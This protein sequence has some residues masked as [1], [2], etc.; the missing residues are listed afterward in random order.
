MKK[1]HVIP[2]I[3]LLVVIAGV[4]AVYQVYVKEQIQEFQENE[5]RI[6]ALKNRIDR[7]EETFKGQDGLPVKPEVAV[8]QW[9]SQVQPFLEAVRRQSR[10]FHFGQA[11]SGVPLVPEN[12]EPKFHYTTEIPKQTY[13]L[14]QYAATNNTILA[15][16]FM[17]GAPTVEDMMGQNPTEE[18]VNDWLT[19]F[20]FGFSI[21][22][23]LV[24]GGAA[25]INE[26]VIWPEREE[27]QLLEMRTV[28][29]RFQ[30]TVDNLA[31]FLEQFY[32]ED[33]YF[34]VNG[35]RIQNSNLLSP[36][37][38]LLDI[39][40]VLT[41]AGFLEENASQGMGAVASVA[42][43]GASNPRVSAAAAL[44]A[45]RKQGGILGRGN[46]EDDDLPAE[47]WWKK[48]WPF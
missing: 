14:Q 26:I 23:M 48:L 8:S 28:G 18:E 6:E 29:L 17:F 22:K 40:L 24:D 33:R 35:I 32:G 7:F 21:V 3:I 36:Q 39:E 15:R 19:E 5:K 13:E 25:R 42:G 9:R 4:A 11:M 43:A 46:D 41:Q 1:H 2:I 16:N 27:M 44:S 38:P 10:Y 30:M 34:N 37:K 31:D 20:R 45:L 47:P 12:Q